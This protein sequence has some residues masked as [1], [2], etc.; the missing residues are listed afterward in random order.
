MKYFRSFIVFTAIVIIEYFLSTNVYSQ[1]PQV[2]VKTHPQ[3]KETCYSIVINV[4]EKISLTTYQSDVN[5]GVIR[6]RSNSTL[7]FNTQ[8]DLLS[9]IV[10]RVLQDLKKEEMHTLFIGRLI[11]AFGNNNTEMSERLAL[12]A[13]TSTLWD[14]VKGSAVAAHENM[15]VKAIAD[16]AHI[17]TELNAIFNK[18]GLDIKVASVEKVLIAQPDKIPFGDKLKHKGMKATAKVPYDCLTWFSIAKGR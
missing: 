7:P 3:Y 16:E 18:H 6:L 5:R 17:F 9:T 4:Q 1:G 10:K 8:I 15:A 12:S 14:S 2:V 11:N 13:Y